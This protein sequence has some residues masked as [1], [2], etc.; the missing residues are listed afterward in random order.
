MEL[1]RYGQRPAPQDWPAF[2]AAADQLVRPHL[3]DLADNRLPLAEGS[4]ANACSPEQ[5]GLTYSDLDADR[6][7]TR[8]K[9]LDAV[10]VLDQWLRALGGTD[11]P[12]LPALTGDVETDLTTLQVH[13]GRVL[14]YAKNRA[15]GKNRA[16]G[17]PSTNTLMLD[18]LSRIPESHGWSIRQFRTEIGRSLPAIQS[19]HAWRN[20]ESLRS[21]EKASRAMDRSRRAGRGKRR[22]K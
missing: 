7:G 17:R 5:F 16:G 8:R 4:G 2:L 20:L 6:E 11:R 1:H 18:V 15:D 14:D 19:T 13:I 12:Q 3:E 10:R 9:L 21:E 22:R